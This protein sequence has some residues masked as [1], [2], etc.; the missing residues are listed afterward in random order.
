MRRSP[1][2]LRGPRSGSC[3]ERVRPGRAAPGTGALPTGSAAHGKCQVIAVAS[4]RPHLT[5]VP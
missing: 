5:G 2:R 4:R 1:F 3:L